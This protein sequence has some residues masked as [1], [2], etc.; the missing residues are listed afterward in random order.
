MQELILLVDR[1]PQ[2]RTQPAMRLVRDQKQGRV[3]MEDGR[4]PTQLALEVETH[5]SDAESDLNDAVAHLRKAARLLFAMSAPW[6]TGDQ[7]TA[8]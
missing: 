6:P 8:E 7:E 4:A 5:L 1:L 3:Q 2:S